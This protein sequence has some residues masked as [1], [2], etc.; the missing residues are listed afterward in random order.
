MLCF[1]VLSDGDFWVCPS[2]LIPS[3]SEVTGAEFW[4][5]ACSAKLGGWNLVWG[6]HAKV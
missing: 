3:Q 4:V 6:S 1:S 5:G 2:S